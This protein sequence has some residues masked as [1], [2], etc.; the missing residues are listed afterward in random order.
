MEKEIDDLFL[1]ADDE[2]VDQNKINT[3]ERCMEEIPKIYPNLEQ[4]WTKCKEIDLSL[5]LYTIKLESLAKE[6]KDI[7]KENTK[8]ENEIRY[9]T[10]IYEHLKELLINVEIKED[11]FIALESESFDSIDGVCKIEKALEVLGSFSVDEYDI[12]IVREKKERIN[13]ALRGFYKR[14]ITYMGSFMVGSESSGE[15]KVHKGLYGAIKRFKKI[16]QHAKRYRDYYVVIC[17]IYVARSKKLYERE[18][19]FHLKTVLR[20]LKESVT[21]DKVDSVFGSLF[22]SYRSIVKCEDRFLK[23]ME[24]EGTCQEIFRNIGLLITEFVEDVYD[25]ADVETLNGLGKSWKEAGPDEDVYG[26]FQKDLRDVYERLEGDYLKKK[27]GRK[28]NGVGKLEEVLSKSSN[29]ELKRRAVILGAQ[30]IMEEED[31]EDLKRIIGRWRQLDRMQKMCSE[32]VC[33]VEDAEKRVGSEFEKSCIDAILGNGNVVE[34]V[35]GVL[36]LVEGEEDFKDKVIKKIREMISNNVEEKEIEEIDKL[37]RKA[38][39][40]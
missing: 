7:E 18:F 32:K 4:V 40:S 1:S 25:I 10:S 22:E 30:R 9:Q 12:R 15:L 35:R 13:D 27:M 24:I 21:Q 39:R 36:S 23:S 19:G 37:L 6:M 2:K 17:S 33:E 11:H 28:E 31:R 5:S 20:L 3:L 16:I 14:F 34:N 8:L 26:T 29:E 38:M